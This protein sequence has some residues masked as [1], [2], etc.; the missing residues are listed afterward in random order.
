M[1]LFFA[2]PSTFASTWTGL[3]GGSIAIFS[4]GFGLAAQANE[5]HRFF[6]SV[7]TSGPLFGNAS[8]AVRVVTGTKPTLGKR[9][10][11]ELVRAGVVKPVAQ[12]R[13]A[14][15]AKLVLLVTDRRL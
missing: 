9:G 1:A 13:S 14:V 5:M 8:L 15:D 2:A 11:G 7:D 3:G 10:L 6:A 4:S 12:V